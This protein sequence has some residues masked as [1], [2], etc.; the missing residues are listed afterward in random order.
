MLFARLENPH[1]KLETL[2]TDH[3][4]E[5]RLRPGVRKYACELSLDPN[6]ANNKL[7]LSGG[8]KRVTCVSEEQPY[9]E[10]PERF[11]DWLQILCKECL[12]GRC[13]WEAEWSGDG[14]R[15]AVAYKSIKRKLRNNDSLV[16]RNAKS[17]TLD[18][19]PDSYSAWHNDDRTMGSVPSSG[20]RR[21]GVYLDWPAGTLSFY[22]V[23]S[24]TLTHLHTFHSTFT[25]PVCPG[26]RITYVDSSAC[27]CH[28]T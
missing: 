24:D 8:N 4:A 17:W 22:S 3:C 19:S 7:F 23:S 1:C 2:N 16:G 20:S 11:D 10:H 13:Y 28:I 5:I 6:T 27:L 26:F 14:A 25:E 21:V 12:S 15:I 9:P 18:C